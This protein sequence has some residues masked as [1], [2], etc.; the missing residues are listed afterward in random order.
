MFSTNSIVQQR[1]YGGSSY[2]GVLSGQLAQSIRSL[3]A[4]NVKD[5]CSRVGMM[6]PGGLAQGDGSMFSHQ[7]AASGYSKNSSSVPKLLSNNARKE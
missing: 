3:T 5:S 6:I 7:L 1:M 4:S 2:H